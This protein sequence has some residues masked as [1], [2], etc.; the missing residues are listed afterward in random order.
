MIWIVQLII[1]YH[2]AQQEHC[3]HGRTLLSIQECCAVDLYQ[4]KETTMRE[5]LRWRLL[6]FHVRDHTVPTDRV[7]GMERKMK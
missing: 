6:L 4:A 3:G 7:G 1:F 2:C 5:I